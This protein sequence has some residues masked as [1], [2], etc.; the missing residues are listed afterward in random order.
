V[1]SAV[2]RGFIPVQDKLYLIAGVKMPEGAS[3]ARTDA[4]LRQIAAIATS[5]DGIDGEIAFPGLNPLQFTNTP[6]SGV[7]FFT[8]DPFDQRTRSAAEITA[9][10]NARIAAEVDS[11][12]G[13]ALMPPPIQ[14]LGNGSG[15]SLFIEDRAA[16]GYGAL[17]EAVAGFQGAVSQTPGMGYPIS[18][19]Q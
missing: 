13:F 19:Y 9:E 3:I 15:Y 11:G 1:F 12:F 17:Q 6:N 10:L 4:T 14:G 16:L 18:S 2:P 7:V 5:I 8:L